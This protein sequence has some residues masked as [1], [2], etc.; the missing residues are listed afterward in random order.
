MN[1]PL[2]RLTDKGIYCEQGD[3]YIDP[4]RSV[5]K[6]IITHAHSDHARSGHSWYLTHRLSEP[7]MR[8]RLGFSLRIETM[9]YHEKRMINGVTISFHPAGHVLGSSQIRLEYK[10]EVWV[11][12]GD[13]KI[14]FDGLSHEFEPVKCHHFIT[15][16]TFGMPVY[17]WRPQ[18]EIFSDINS[19]WNE[20]KQN[21]KVSILLGYSL[22]KAQRLIWNIEHNIGPVYVHSSIENINEAFLMGGI[23]LPFT[24]NLNDFKMSNKSEGSLILI[25]PGADYVSLLDSKADC[26]IGFV[27]G[28]MVFKKSRKQM[29]TDRNFTLSDH[30]DWNGL[31][32]AIKQTEAEHIYV[33]HGVNT[34]FSQ[35]LTEI[36]Y[37]ATELSTPFAQNSEE[38]T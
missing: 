28:W 30:A 16:A 12:S 21:G 24:Q 5:E 22:G 9:E 4:W 23:D 37:H 33:T 20:N 1:K 34:F 11:A 6:A 10:G 36:G 19:W 35:Y 31:L 25:P 8:V 3:F 26:S 2:L 13:Y 18:H 17:Q 14:E 32:H 15:E 29:K 38:N 7:I 27:S